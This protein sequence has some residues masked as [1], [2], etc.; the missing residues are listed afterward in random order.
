MRIQKFNEILFEAKT[1]RKQGPRTNIKITID[2][3]IFLNEEASKTLYEVIDY[4]SQKIGIENFIEFAKEN[5]KRMFISTNIQDFADY[6]KNQIKSNKTNQFYIASH[7]STFDK[8]EF[9]EMLIKGLNLNGTVE[10]VE[11][12]NKFQPSKKS[13]ISTSSYAE[14]EENLTFMDA[15]EEVLKSKNNIPMTAKQIW[16]EIVKNKLIT[17][18]KGKTPESSSLPQMMSRNFDRFERFE[19]SPLTFRLRFLDES[20]VKSKDI[21]LSDEDIKIPDTDV[22]KFKSDYKKNPFGG[23]NE[24]SSICILGKSGVGKS[25]T[26]D[27]VLDNSGHI[28]QFIIPSAT[29]TA[30]LSQ[31]SPSAKDG[32]GGYIPSRLGKMIEEAFRNPSK[33]YTA[34]FDECHKSNVIEMINDE[35]LQ[36]ISKVRNKNRFIS[37]DDETADLYPSKIIDKRGNIEIP[38]NMGFIFISSNARVISGNDDFYNRVDL[39]EIT[40]DNRENIKTISDLNKLRVKTKAEKDELVSKLMSK[41]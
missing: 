32:S 25:Y 37:L 15:A 8:K 17:S 10:L 26:I 1:Q 12:K 38:D 39:V 40:D 11:G 41:K 2:N 6:K 9:I 35:L 28:Y 36:A 14:F 29:T 3:N 30:L 23:E 21:L 7:S 22:I 33:L 5:Q 18:W 13:E 34:V 31:F 19:T 20:D 16:D 4:I 24:T 27:D